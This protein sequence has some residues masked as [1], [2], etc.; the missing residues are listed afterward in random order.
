MRARTWRWAAGA[1]LVLLPAAIGSAAQAQAHAQEPAVARAP[2]R[3]VI[4]APLDSARVRGTRSP[5]GAPGP[6][7]WQNSADYD[8]GVQITPA[9][10]LLRGQ[11]RV[12]YHNNSP[13]PLHAVVFR[14]Y[15]NLM[16]PYSG[17]EQPVPAVTRGMIVDSLVANGRAVR[18]PSFPTAVALDTTGGARVY[19]TLMIVP[20]A[21][22]LAPGAT[23]SFDVRWHF[24]IPGAWAP[25]MGM[26][27]PTTGQI[28]QWYPQIAVYDDVHGWDQQQYTGTGEFYLDYGHFRYAVTLP[29]GFVVGGTGVLQ[30]PQAVLNADELAALRRSAGTSDVVHVLTRDR[31]GPGK[32][33]KGVAGS[34]ITWEFVADSVRDVA[35]AFG[36]HYLWDATS[37]VVDSA[38]GRR[39]AV[40]VLYRPDAPRFDQVWKMAQYALETH[41]SRMVPYPWPQLTV[42]EGGSGGMEYPM[43][44]FDQA[45]KG[46][47][48][49]DMV[50]AHEIGHEWFPM[51]V[52]SNETQYGWQD[53]GLNTFDTFFATD[54]FIPDSVR[55]GLDESQK[56]YTD[57]VNRSDE[58]FTMMSPANAFGVVPNSG[59]DPEA[60]EKPASVLWAL[61]A[62]LGN[63]EF[64]RAYRSYIAR[65]AY[66]HPTAY[67]FFATFDDVT[68]R[69]LDPFFFQWWFTN[70]QLDQAI[71]AVSQTGNRLGV[72]VRNV[73]QIMMPVDVTARLA[74]GRSMTWREPMTAWYDGRTELTTSHEV[75]G[76]VV[77][78][79]LDA[80]HNFPDVDRANNV[81]KK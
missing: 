71:T 15:Q 30:N 16:G 79:E 29:A 10:S 73:G 60:Y 18:L 42:S 54:A 64:Y 41:S 66:R 27:D 37:A 12:T 35:F 46:L 76:P 38:H 11:E 31:F 3:L 8:I 25:R 17:R 63:D 65:W 20:L 78:V 34:M 28:A 44:V 70:Q 57:F 40:N 22:P 2:V 43:T 5:T 47:Y 14:L 19:G 61:R 1:A 58:V 26:D 51:M 56:T 53:E 55:H 67:D 75:P 13:D 80:D 32:A 77:S 68:H 48:E 45:Y 9:D 33:T 59:Y 4:P 24:T 21:T 39:A 72:T 50:T 23:A 69:D 62:V 74:D 81:W 36:D 6:R 52:G 7:Y 49:S